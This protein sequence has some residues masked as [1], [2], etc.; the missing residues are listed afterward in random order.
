MVRVAIALLLFALLPSPVDVKLIDGAV[1]SS[2]FRARQPFP[3][4]CR[5]KKQF[6]P[7][8]FQHNKFNWNSNYLRARAEGISNFREKHH[9]III[10]RPGC[11]YCPYRYAIRGKDWQAVEPGLSLGD[12]HLRS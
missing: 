9:E 3:H 1:A 11:C 2:I 6:N 5:R 10:I 7:I 8:S 12:W 4:L